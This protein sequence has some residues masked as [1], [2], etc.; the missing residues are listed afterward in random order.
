MSLTT[1]INERAP[2]PRSLW[3]N[4]DYMFLWSGQLVSTLGTGVSSIAFPLLALALTHSAAQAG[5]L[6]AFE[7]L[8]YL[9]FSLPAGALVDRWDRKRVMVICDTGR[10]FVPLRRGAL[11]AIRLRPR[12]PG[13]L[14]PLPAGD[15]L[16]ELRNRR[17]Q[18]R[19]RGLLRRDCGPRRSQRLHLISCAHT[20]ILAHRPLFFLPPTLR[21]Y[22]GA[23]RGVHLA[24]DRARGGGWGVHPEGY[25]GRGY[26]V[27]VAAAWGCAVRRTGRLALYGHAWDSAASRTVTRRLGLH[28]IGDEINFL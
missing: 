26:A 2:A 15:A 25:R 11:R 16:L 22:R 7:S 20:P 6:G 24:M 5:L 14:L 3:R 18:L 10:P 4:R 1:D 13:R 23:V 28:L 27:A 19:N 8:P 9:I 21:C 12:R 17:L